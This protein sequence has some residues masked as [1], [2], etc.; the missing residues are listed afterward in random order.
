MKLRSR[1][2][3]FQIRLKHEA[4]AGHQAS[5]L[6]PTPRALAVSTSNATPSYSAFP[7]GG[8]G[9]TA[10]I[11]DTLKPTRADTHITESTRTERCLRPSESSAQQSL[12][13]EVT[14][15]HDPADA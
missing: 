10:G 2:F 6:S 15:S 14:L 1:R 11:R 13:N 9:R 5:P 8:G 3:L 12:A 4:S 7:G